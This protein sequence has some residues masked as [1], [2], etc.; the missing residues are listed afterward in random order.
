MHTWCAVRSP[1]G[2]LSR[3]TLA[4][5]LPCEGAR[6]PAYPHQELGPPDNVAVIAITVASAVSI[7][8]VPSCGRLCDRL[9]RRPLI[10]AGGLAIAVFAGPF[11]LLAGTKATPLI[12]MAVIL[13]FAG[14]LN[15]MIFGPAGSFFSELLPAEVRCTGL[16]LA[17]ETTAVLFSGTAPFIA[18][19]LCTRVA[20]AQGCSSRVARQ[21]RKTGPECERPE[22][23]LPGAGCRARALAAVR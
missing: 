18:T 16:D 20:E 17:R 2:R 21:D 6:A 23:P 22:S 11:W 9:G 19:L 3:N 8:G 13:G 4:G 14:M 12:V 10:T 5:H 15:S 7:F 1:G